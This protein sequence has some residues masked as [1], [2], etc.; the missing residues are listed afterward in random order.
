MTSRRLRGFSLALLWALACA[1]ALAE[2][3]GLRNLVV[4]RAGNT[5]V[6][7]VARDQSRIA[8]AVVDASG[9]L[10]SCRVGDISVAAV[11]A[12]RDAAGFLVLIRDFSSLP[13]LTRTLERWDGRGGVDWRY[14]TRGGDMAPAPD[15]GAVLWE[16][17]H[18]RPDGRLQSQ[19]LRLDP[20]G[21]LRWRAD[22]FA[23]F[24]AP[25][26]VSMNVDKLDRV[27]FAAEPHAAL[28]VAGPRGPARLGLVGADGQLAWLHQEPSFTLAP[29]VLLDD[30]SGDL[31]WFLGSTELV[32]S[33]VT[34]LPSR[35]QRWTPW[36]LPLVA[37]HGPAMVAGTEITQPAL[38]DGDAVWFVAQGV[39]RQSELVRL[40][41]D[42][43]MARH[44]I[45]PDL[46]VRLAVAD[47]S[48]W[49]AGPFAGNS[50]GATV[51]ASLERFTEV[52]LAW[53]RRLNGRVA[54]WGLAATHDGAAHLAA[55]GS[56]RE[57][58]LSRLTPR[59]GD[60]VW[61]ISLNAVAD[62][63]VAR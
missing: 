60:E 26:A 17:V 13:L 24:L 37:Y 22:V 42:G 44:R 12:R 34:Y 31:W 8:A 29:S 56:D 1:S 49:L 9:Q 51:S 40:S 3:A 28:I 59:R 32:A 39:A 18:G 38:D 53:S 10:A 14:V 43:R 7:L 63:C 19:M 2:Q 30:G 55:A 45:R 58:W 20:D 57:V 27:H 50:S 11:H 21:G 15:G 48:A 5:F 6:E 36:G 23:D 25:R 47:G 33:T 35:L 16:E 46:P 54:V 52:G 62:A 61:R 4:D 41:T